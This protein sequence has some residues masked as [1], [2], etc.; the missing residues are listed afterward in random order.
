M[1]NE[2]TPAN[3]LSCPDTTPN[4]GLPSYAEA[5]MDN[6]MQYVR[7]ILNDPV[8]YNVEKLCVEFPPVNTSTHI[9]K[10]NTSFMNSSQAFK[11]RGNTIPSLVENTKQLMLEIDLPLQQ[12]GLVVA[13]GIFSS[14]HMTQS[15]FTPT[16]DID[17]FI[18]GTREQAMHNVRGFMEHVKSL[19]NRHLD[20]PLFIATGNCITFFLYNI[21]QI[22][23]R[24]P[25]GRSTFEREKIGK[26][27]SSYRQYQIICR[28]HDEPHQV[29]EKFDLAPAM[30]YYWDNTLFM[31]AEA[32][33]AYTNCAMIL[34]L[35]KRRN[36]FGY[37]L[38]KYLNRGFHLLLTEVELGIENGTVYGNMINGRYDFDGFV[39]T[40][41]RYNYSD[42]IYFDTLVRAHTAHSF[43]S[44][45]K[46]YKLEDLAFDNLKAICSYTKTGNKL[47]FTNIAGIIE[48]FNYPLTYK[49]IIKA[50][51]KNMQLPLISLY[52]LGII[53]DID[54]HSLL[55]DQLHDRQ[56]NDKLSAIVDNIF[57][58]IVNINSND[59]NISSVNFEVS[60][61]HY[62][63]PIYEAMCPQDKSPEKF[64]GKHYFPL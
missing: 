44:S 56:I 63:H 22:S 29:I 62:T 32:V 41:R 59:E 57:N 45:N 27:D 4:V 25:E 1:S 64:Y 7:K 24:D 54:V 39:F 13:G 9:V 18:V 60:F 19:K 42:I 6:D 52:K 2:S 5:T 58:R 38:T 43:Y 34:N 47:N 33:Y 35:A 30:V 23:Q 31:S 12:F 15:T 26:V 11:I 14:L 3:A 48:E 55:E 16:S 10:L 21:F 36:N 46:S 61:E 40:T 17:L 28:Y 53:G 8:I 20:R 50:C 37:R 51:D 49:M